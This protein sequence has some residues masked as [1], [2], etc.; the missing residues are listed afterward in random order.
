VTSTIG[1]KVHLM[2]SAV[3]SEAAIDASSWASVGSQA[4]DSP[5]EI[6]YMVLY[7][8]MTSSEKISGM[9]SRDWSAAC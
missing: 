7:P 4:L 1:L 9:C 6:G 3:A 5:R 2:P 8:W